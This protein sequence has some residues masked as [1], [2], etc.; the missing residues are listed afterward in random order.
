MDTKIDTAEKNVL[1]D[2]VKLAQKRG[3]KGN[4]GNWKEFLNSYDK[5]FGA[6]M[7][8][9]GKRSH[10]D[11]AAFL[12]TFSKDDDLKFFANIMR[13]HSNQYMVER[14]LNR[15][16]DSPEQ[17]LVQ[18]TLQH[19]L[20]P[21]DYSLPSID[22]GWI[23]I[24]LQKK[25]KVLRS[26]AMVAIDCEMVKCEDESE[27]LVKVCV[28]D[29]NLEVKLHE[30]VKP[31]KAIIDYKTDITGVSSQDLE[32]V[33][34][35]LADIQKKLKRLLSNGTILVGHSLHNDLRVLKLDYVRVV[36]TAYIFQPL[37]GSIHR[38][39][40]LNSLCQAVLGHKV[41]EK[42]ASHDCHDDACAAMKL[43]QARIKHGVDKPFPYT[44]V[45]EHIAESDMAKL[46]IHGIPTIVSLEMLNKIVPGDFK[47]ERKASRFGLGDKYAAIA[48]FKNQ[49]KANDAFANV[50][51]SEA[52]DSYG[53]PQ[54][55]VTFQLSTGM[56]VGLFVRKMATD[57]YRDAIQATKKLKMDPEIEALNKQL[58]ERD[59]E[60]ESL[61]EQLKQKDS[62]ISTHL[63]EI[64][65]LNQQLKCNSEVEQMK[66]QLRVKDFDISA[67]H[68]MVAS[69]KKRKGIA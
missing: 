46:L 48:I 40:S 8:D 14:L 24:N 6:N 10:E 16:D 35:S 17:R 3:M 39:P 19:P 68:K 22:E 15:S 21:L 62:E 20:Y 38:R 53:R 34:R 66:E 52:K 12:K 60:V 1:V 47:V 44:L 45:E 43:A 64:E 7:S 5:K 11:L 41:R 18:A 61:R 31:D 4:L 37:D 13:H 63:K 42:G 56:T 25:S 30:L 67:L 69:L 58:K 59:M 32:S 28:V 36:D 9:P 27:A 2:I 49:E 51:G 55:F 29:H 33:T 23:V 57:G 26:A 50:Q 54:K 65:A